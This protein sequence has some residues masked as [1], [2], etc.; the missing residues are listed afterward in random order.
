MTS[1]D[2][3]CLIWFLIPELDISFCI[4]SNIQRCLVWSM[5]EVATAEAQWHRSRW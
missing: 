4:D 2:S 3:E 5:A 1:C